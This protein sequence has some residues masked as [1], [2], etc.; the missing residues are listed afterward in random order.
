R[1]GAKVEAE[2]ATSGPGVADAAYNANAAALQGHVGA[3]PTTG[4]TEAQ[5]IENLRTVPEMRFSSES[6]AA[7]HVDKHVGE[8]P[9][10]E[11]PA[12]SSPAA[13]VTA[14]L[15]SATETVHTGA[16]TSGV[17][18]D[19]TRT[20]TFTRTVAEGSQSYT[21]QAIVVLTD[22]GHA[23]LATYFSTGRK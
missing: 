1:L 14:Y 9:P 16:V 23:F 2:F 6:A 22:D 4:A 11:A 5:V 13:R 18:Q 12:S 17:N 7:Y 10:S 8:L 15:A 19:G 3:T 20:L 21:M